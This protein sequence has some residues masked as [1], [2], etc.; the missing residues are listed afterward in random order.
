MTGK[1]KNVYLYSRCGCQ[2]NRKFNCVRHESTCSS[3][4]EG[5]ETVCKNCRKPFASYRDRHAHEKNAKVNKKSKKTQTFTCSICNQTFGSASALVE[6]E[7]Q[8]KHLVASSSSQNP[9]RP[10]CRKCGTVCN[11]FKELY[12][13]RLE[14]HDKSDE[15]RRTLQSGPWIENNTTPPW[16]TDDDDEDTFSLKTTYEQHKHLILKQRKTTGTIKTSYNFPV[17]NQLSV[18]QMM[19]HLD[20][21]YEDNRFCFK[22]N[23]SIGLLLQHLETGSI[24]YFV[25]YH[26]ETVFYVPIYVRSRRELDRIRSRLEQLDV[27]QYVRKQRP[28]TTNIVYGIFIT[29]YTLGCGQ[30]LPRY[31]TKCKSIISFEKHKT[32]R[33][34]TNNKCFFRCLAFDRSRKKACELLTNELHKQWLCYTKSITLKRHKNYSRP[35]AGLRKILSGKY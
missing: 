20:E 9:T 6:H 25:P 15:T 19:S 29:S 4:S 30:T 5:K 17:P 34:Y 8:S 23:I 33:L 11:S 16:D 32:G 22:V 2:F 1:D 27:I 7:N 28:N 31:L 35:D 24:R 12:L 10:K 21:I 26:N 14:K 18:D 13:Y 3:I